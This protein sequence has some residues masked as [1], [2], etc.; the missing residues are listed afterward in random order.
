MR[1]RCA[2]QLARERS[3]T[4]PFRAA[5]DPPPAKPPRFPYKPPANHPPRRKPKPKPTAVGESAA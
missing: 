4:R 2:G 1:S 3:M 5:G